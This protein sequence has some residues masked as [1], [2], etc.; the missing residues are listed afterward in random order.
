MFHI[1]HEIGDTVWVE[2]GEYSASRATITG[3]HN[4]GYYVHFIDKT[5][6]Q[7]EDHHFPVLSKSVRPLDYIGWEK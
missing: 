7:D 6:Y 2:T 3:I 4:D 5:R 1:R